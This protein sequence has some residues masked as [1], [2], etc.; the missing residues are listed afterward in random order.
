LAAR[1]T[2]PTTTTVE[3]PRIATAQSQLILLGRSPLIMNRLSEKARHELLA[4][5]GRKT[6][7]ARASSL[8][9]DP[10]QEFHAAPHRI[11]DVEAPTLLGMPASAVKGALMT[12][13]LDLPGAKRTQIGRLV[14]VEGGE[15]LPVYGMPQLLM[16]VVRSA[17]MNKTPD[18]RTRVIVS[19]WC[20]VVDV[21]YVMPLIQPNSLQN[22]AYAAG[23]TVGIG[24]YR[25]EK[26]KGSYGSFDIVESVD[27]PRIRK[28]MAGDVRLLQE[29]AMDRAEPYDTDTKDLLSWW[30][31]DARSQSLRS[32]IG[33]VEEARAPRGRAAANGRGRRAT[34]VEVE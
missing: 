15:L 7:A 17:D 10:I 2:E 6:A 3:I 31:S 19:A 28:L 26:G 25:Q 23:L 30:Q 21:S 13:A 20:M 8:K 33:M 9:H 27:D 4:P 16:S 24:D 29:D 14:W 34:P 12:A 22:L 32:T 5:S 18:I 1:K 11:A